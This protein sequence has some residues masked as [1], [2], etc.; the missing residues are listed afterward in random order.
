MIQKRSDYS[1]KSLLSGITFLGVPT[2]V[3]FHGCQYFLTVINTICT[4][5]ITAYVFMPVFYK[6]QI[7]STYEYLE[8]RFSRRTR[9]FASSLYILSLLVYVPIVIYVP[10]LAISQVTG[11]SIHFISPVLSIICITYTS[12]V[13]FASPIYFVVQ[14]III[15]INNQ[16]GVKAVVWTD[17]IQFVFTI[18]GLVTV[19]VIG[20]RSVGGFFNVWKISNNGGRLD[21]FEYNTSYTIFTGLMNL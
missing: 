15:L 11:F 19:L 3:Y 14:K 10:A 18:G 16:G 17:T 7:S 21:I 20:I 9:C 8:L 6:L 5:F 2:E 4:G 1:P 12:M 13:R